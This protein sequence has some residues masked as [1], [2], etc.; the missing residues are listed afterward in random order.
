MKISSV[1]ALQ[2]KYE[3]KICAEENSKCI[4]TGKEYKSIKIAAE[5]LGVHKANTVYRRKADQ[6]NSYFSTP[7]K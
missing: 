3:L 7:F 1:R 2:E 6:A 5:R 4:K